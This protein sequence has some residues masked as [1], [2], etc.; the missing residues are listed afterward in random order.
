MDMNQAAKATAQAID[1]S[2]NSLS[3]WGAFENGFSQII[4]PVVLA[5]Q[6]RGVLPTDQAGALKYLN[7]TRRIF[8]EMVSGFDN[9]NVGMNIKVTNKP[10]GELGVIEF[11]PAK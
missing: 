7:E 4:E 3:A 9:K 6:A 5:D 11:P 2:D 8:A 10:S 1:E